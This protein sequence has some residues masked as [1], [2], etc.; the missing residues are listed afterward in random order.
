MLYCE[1]VTVFD[2]IQKIRNDSDRG[3]GIE[4]CLILVEKEARQRLVRPFLE[5]HTY[6]FSINPF[7]HSCLSQL[8]FILYFIRFCFFSWKHIKTVVNIY[9]IVGRWRF[10]KRVKKMMPTQNKKFIRLNEM[11]IIR[12]VILF[13]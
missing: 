10:N 6:A 13:I 1:F 2:S 9:N 7:L 3:S 5:N 12:F 4:I 11:Q 8:L